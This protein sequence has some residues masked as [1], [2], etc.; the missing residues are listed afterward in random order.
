MAV[1]QKQHILDVLCPFCCSLFVW[2]TLCMSLQRV[3]AAAATKP[4]AR[5]RH[6]HTVRVWRWVLCCFSAQLV[7][8]ACFFQSDEQFTSL[9]FW[10]QAKPAAQ[11]SSTPL[12][13]C[14]RAHHPCNAFMLRQLQHHKVRNE[15]ALLM[16]A[17]VVSQVIIGT[18][19][20]AA[21]AEA[22]AATGRSGQP[23]PED[24]GTLISSMFGERPTSL[25][26]VRHSRLL[27]QRLNRDCC[28]CFEKK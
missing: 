10:N 22:A 7:L 8:S 2:G 6:C 5:C 18:N 12:R 3:K 16:T 21:A 23:V 1:A 25:V 20:E 13:A 27:S 14:M 4:M 26:V 11:T 9:W 24:W 19:V 17:A 15:H 28:D